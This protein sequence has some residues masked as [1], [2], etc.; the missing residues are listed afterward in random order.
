MDVENIKM[1]KL[2]VVSLVMWMTDTCVNSV[3]NSMIK[4]YLLAQGNMSMS[5]CLRVKNGNLQ[6]SGIGLR[7]P[8]MLL[9]S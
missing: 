4:E 7:P 2:M 9:L 1:L 3:P 5:A 8:A 6:T